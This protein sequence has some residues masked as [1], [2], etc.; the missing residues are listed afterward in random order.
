MANYDRVSLL[1]SGVKA[2]G[3]KAYVERSYGNS[4]VE[5][6][7]FSHRAEDSSRV[8]TASTSHPQV[9]RRT[10]PADNRQY[11]QT[12]RETQQ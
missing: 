12:K 8:T 11:L 6:R 2:Y 9:H 5:Q 10:P 3:V 4:R 1:T 7:G